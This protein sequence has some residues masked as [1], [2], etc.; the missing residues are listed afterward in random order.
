MEYLPTIRWL[1][2]L[3]QIDPSTVLRN[4]QIFVYIES[5]RTRGYRVTVSFRY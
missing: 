4:Y 5:D 2:A 3:N 1:A